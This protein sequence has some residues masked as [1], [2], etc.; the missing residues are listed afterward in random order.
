MLL[1]HGEHLSCYTHAC[2]SRH[3]GVLSAGVGTGG[4]ITGAGR[5]LKQQKPSIQL[6]AVEPDE[7]AV[8]SGDQPGYHQVWRVV[9]T[10]C[11]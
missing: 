2:K 7:S 10:C 1:Y 3:E 5:F 11:V 8:L 9:L 4:T 6:V